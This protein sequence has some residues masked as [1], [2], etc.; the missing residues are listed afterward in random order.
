MAALR[1]ELLFAPR[2]RLRVGMGAQAGDRLRAWLDGH[3]PAGALVIGFS[4]ATRAGV[5][6][7]TVLLAAEILGNGSD[8]IPLDSARVAKAKGALPD[9]VAGAV[10]TVTGPA[11]PADKARRGVDALAV[12]M[13][14]AHLARELARRGTPFLVVRV[15]LDELWEDVLGSPRIRWARRALACAR[16]LGRA[17][18]ALRPVLEGR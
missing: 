4:G 2:P 8:P 15:V 9:A 16:R 1:T 3:E 10:A 6:A 14:S 18:A 7:G 17:A 5:G 11:A 13:E 12:D